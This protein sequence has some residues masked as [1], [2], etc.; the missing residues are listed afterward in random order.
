MGG[1]DVISE[2]VG[3]QMCTET[4]GAGY[5]IRATTGSGEDMVTITLDFNGAWGE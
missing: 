3:Y 5:L 2:A 1:G 4:Q